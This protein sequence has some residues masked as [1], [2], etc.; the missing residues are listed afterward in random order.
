MWGLRREAEKPW[1]S[2]MSFPDPP[3]RQ[4][5]TGP[6]GGRRPQTPVVL[7][8]DDGD[9]DD[10]IV[11]VASS[12]CLLSAKHY[13]SM[14]SVLSYSSNPLGQFTGLIPI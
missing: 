9:N 7:F 1:P 6:S 11:I 10:D 2:P 4:L 13:A 14:S 12:E 5:R 8:D 3:P